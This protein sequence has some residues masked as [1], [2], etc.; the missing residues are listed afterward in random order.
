MPRLKIGV[1]SE[2]QT[3]SARERLPP[4]LPLLACRACPALIPY[5]LLRTAS[6]VEEACWEIAVPWVLTK[7]SS[8]DKEKEETRFFT[9]V[10]HL[11]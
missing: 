4:I 9:H 10:Q 1:A 3:P 7:I 8:I 11:T 2:T 5:A 6:A